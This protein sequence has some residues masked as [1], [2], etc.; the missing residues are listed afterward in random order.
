MRIQ[1]LYYLSTWCC[2]LW[3]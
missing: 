3:Y 2:H 1:H